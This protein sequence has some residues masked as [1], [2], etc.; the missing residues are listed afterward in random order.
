MGALDLPMTMLFADYEEPLALMPTS[1]C[2]IEREVVYQYTD[3]TGQ[4]L[5]QVVRQPG[6]RFRQRRPDGKGGWIWNLD[7]VDR[8]LYRLPG[9]LAAAHDQDVF[10]VEGEKDVESLRAAGQI[11]TTNP[12]GAGKWR[13]PHSESLR[14][15][16]VVLLP[17]Q[18]DPGRKHAQQVAQMLD[19]VA[20]SVRIVNLA[21][22][23]VKDV[24][25]W[26]A[27]GHTVQELQALATRATHWDSRSSVPGVAVSRKA[28]HGRTP[29]PLANDAYHGLLGRIVRAIEPHT[30]SDPVAILIQ[31]LVAVGNCIGRGPHFRV[32][33]TEH[34]AILFAVCVGDSSKA[35]KGTSWGHVRRLVGMVDPD[36]AERC[37]A[38]GLSS[39][40]GVIH[41]IRDAIPRV[42]KNGETEVVDP[43]VADKRLLVVESEFASVLRVARRDGNTLTAIVRAAWDGDT[44]QTMT[45]NSPCKATRP[46]VSIIGHITR[47]DL[48]RYLDST[49]LANGFA[50]RVLWLQVRRS[51]ELPNGGAL[52]A[53]TLAPLVEELRQV[54]AFARH[55]WAVPIAR[56]AEADA[57]WCSVYHALSEGRPGMCGAVLGRGEAQVVRLSL[58]YALLDRSPVI[59]AP[60]L[61]AAL[62]LWDYLDESA[63]AIFGGGL[64][65]RVA[66]EL[67]RILRMTPEG[68][69]RHELRRE[70]SGHV[71]DLGRALDM[72]ARHRLAYAV[73]V[74]TDGRPAERWF[75]GQEPGVESAESV[76]SQPF[77]AS[78]ASSA[79]AV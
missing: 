69:T 59:R 77:D 23:G 10:V 11:A 49:D 68:M 66:D 64:G 76:G 43:G 67:L 63:Q 14:G 70:F 52:D 12:G 27:A 1:A 7:G 53:S 47:D 38:N 37:L 79:G 73:Q 29:T 30:E 34:H 65:D 35:R 5:F 71:R 28:N 8:P 32:E 58:L 61:R 78:S 15:R 25:D 45:K 51:K 60:H 4:I 54:V 44:L 41:A 74:P 40:E 13:L 75:A 20:A 39:G 26:L 16:S 33:A 50:N 72:L 21:E 46:Y 3:E 19:G 6:K 57:I 9:L 24:S 62:A 48:L 22:P 31:L 2:S 56:D 42:S 17:D 36:W 55:D 18:D